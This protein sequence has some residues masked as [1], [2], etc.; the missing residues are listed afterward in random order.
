[1]QRD[2]QMFIAALTA[3]LVI[4]IALVIYIFSHQS[5]K[6]FVRLEQPTIVTNQDAVKDF[7]QKI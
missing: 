7:A 5:P 1:M 3:T 4:T 6:I 2:T